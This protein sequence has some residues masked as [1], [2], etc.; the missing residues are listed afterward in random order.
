MG[1]C[2]TDSYADPRMETFVLDARVGGVLA[3]GSLS[4]L[5]T[6][7]TIGSVFIFQLSGFSSA[8]WLL[9]VAKL[10]KGII[11]LIF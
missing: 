6:D 7:S 4:V 5:R 11:L 10:C 9:M 2:T 3:W 1:I 8:S